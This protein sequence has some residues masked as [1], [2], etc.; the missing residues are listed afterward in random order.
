MRLQFS[1]VGFMNWTDIFDNHFFQ[2]LQEKK[3][4]STTQLLY[5]QQGTRLFA[6]MS[7]NGRALGTV[8]VST[9]PTQPGHAASPPAAG[10]CDEKVQQSCQRAYKVID[11]SIP[12]L[13]TGESGV[14]KEWLA[15]SIHQHSIR[16]DKPFVAVNCAAIPEHLLESELFGYVAGAFTGA[17]R[18]GANGR[19]RDAH[20]GTLFL[21]EIGNMPVAA[22]TRLLR[23]L[24]ERK[25]T[26]LGSGVATDIN[27]NLICATHQNL[28]K[29]IEQGRFRAD[30][31][32]RINGLNV[33]LP[34]L[35]ERSDFASLCD[36]MLHSLA[37]ELPLQLEPTLREAFQRY[38][39]PGNLRQ[40]HHVLRTAVA[41]LEDHEYEITWSHLADDLAKELK[42][43][44][45]HPNNA[46]SCPAQNLLEISQRAI[47]HALENARGNI[48]AAARQLGISRQTL[49]RKLQTP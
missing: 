12:I 19:L 1:D 15:Q 24:Q 31:Y 6:K 29:A 38:A 26:P 13:I 45:I 37:P 44:T 42:N 17:A 7:S 14:G 49:Y 16:R 2:F 8:S 3:S 36:S 47:Q 28:K 21:D 30:L 43:L 23:V 46:E 41:L 10:H 18:Q 33:E 11:K 9:A 39:W 35:R 34:A 40:L 4:G 48:S 20:E 22:Q 5:T 32:Y 27:F 25:V